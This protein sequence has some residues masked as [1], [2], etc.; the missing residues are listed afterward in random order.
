[1]KNPKAKIPVILLTGFLGSGK[2]T[3][4]NRILKLQDFKNS[5]VI[6]N[7]FG[8][9]PVDHILV[10]ESAETI[11]ELS[12]GCLCCNMRGELVETLARLD[13]ERFDRIFIETTGIADPLPIFQTLA[14]NPDMS[15]RLQPSLIISVFDLVRGKELLEAHSEARRQIA[16]ADQILLTK[17]DLAPDE[18]RIP[19]VL[20]KLNPAAQV[21]FA[22]EIKSLDSLIA[23]NPE[24]PNVPVS[25]HSGKYRSMIMQTDN[26]LSVNDLVG[27]LHMMVNQFGPDLLRIKGFAYVEENPDPLIVQVSG[28][29]VHDLE[30]ASGSISWQKDETLLVAIVKDIDPARVVSIFDGFVGNVATG[31]PDRDALLDNPLAIPGV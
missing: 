1:M 6:V 25:V 19:C 2:T 28:S 20:R 26:R 10:E 7:E 11:Y 21:S 15:A 27:M 17:Q 24:K 23:V 9:V 29:I 5:L 22:S 12:N 8:A 31:T 14:F 30:P 4:L 13:L 18:N 3:F 16:V